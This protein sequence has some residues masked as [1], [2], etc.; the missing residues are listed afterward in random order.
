MS[1]EDK[2]ADAQKAESADRQKYASRAFGIAQSYDNALNAFGRPR[3]RGYIQRLIN[4]S[5]KTTS[6]IKC[7]LKDA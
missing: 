5:P 4:Y 1:D 7:C 3:E 2:V 6:S